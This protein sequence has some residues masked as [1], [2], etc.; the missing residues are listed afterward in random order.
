MPCRE[1]HGMDGNSTVEDEAPKLAGLHEVY[2][3]KQLTDF[4]DKTRSH[5]LMREIKEIE[6]L[7][8]KDIRDLAA[9]YAIQNRTRERRGR[10][11]VA[12]EGKKVYVF[13]RVEDEIPPCKACHGARG[14][15]Y[16][17]VIEGGYPSIG[18]QHSEYIQQQLVAF[19]DGRRANDPTG[20]MRHAAEKLTD[21]DI[22]TLGTYIEGLVSEKVFTPEDWDSKKSKKPPERPKEKAK[23]TPIEPPTEKPEEPPAEETPPEKPKEAPTDPAAEKPKEPPTDPAAEKPEEPPTDPAAEKPEEPPTDPPAETSTEEP[24]EEPKEKPETPPEK[25]EKVPPEK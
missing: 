13:G 10:A 7:K 24:K 20:V 23:E 14:G 18:A 21:R 11:S 19:R 2:I 12:M 3:V 5:E 15:G 1:C 8:D 16:A 25:D 6:D 17:D 9:W 4:R 22:L